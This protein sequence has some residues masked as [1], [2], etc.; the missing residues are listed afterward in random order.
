MRH[1]TASELVDLAEGTRAESSAPH[2]RSCEQCR[3]ELVEARAM[4][5]VATKAVVPEP[6]PLFW[7]YLSRRVHEAVAAEGSV[8][9]ASWLSALQDWTSSRLV[10][11][12]S[13]GATAAVIV[14]LGLALKS[15]PPGGSIPA[16][17][18]VESVA[19][20]DSVAD[21]TS[22]NDDPSLTLVAALASETDWDGNSEPELT[23]R[24]GAADKAVMDLSDGERRELERL[25]KEALVHRGG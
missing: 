24:L 15:R 8:P 17:A 18:A 14:A 7:D 6:S 19:T 22:P 13:A 1:L 3:Q 16:A 20:V 9:R 5:T 2:L 21:S 12:V 10:W 11:L 25:L 23:T 4:L